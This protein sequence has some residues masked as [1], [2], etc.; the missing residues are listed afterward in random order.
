MDPRLWVTPRE[1]EIARLALEL[2]SPE[3]IY[4]FMANIEYVPDFYLK[5]PIE[6][7]HSRVG[8]CDE[9]S[10]LLCSL[11]C[12]MGEQAYVR[13]SEFPGHPVL[14]AWVIWFD[15]ARQEWVNLDPS[16]TLEFADL[17]YG[18]DVPIVEYVDFNDEVVYDYGGLA[19]VQEIFKG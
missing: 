10:V 5:K 14:H 4:D 15:Q 18:V 13:I 2:E 3:R 7:L 16:G 12:A 11:L 8:D 19:R 1:P 9:Q 17:G 6:V